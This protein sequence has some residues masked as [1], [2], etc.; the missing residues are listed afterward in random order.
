MAIWAKV[1]KQMASK[2]MPLFEAMIKYQDM[3]AEQAM[4][5]QGTDTGALTTPAPE[6]MAAEEQLPGI[7]PAAMAGL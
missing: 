5:S 1:R 6:E 4:A 2:G 7:P 3:L